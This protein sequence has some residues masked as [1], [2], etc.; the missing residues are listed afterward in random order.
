VSG[1]EES[2]I[3]QIANEL[4]FSHDE[5]VATRLKYSAQRTILRKGL[6]TSAS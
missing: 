3:W 4:G 2:Q 6:D 5:Y 1:Q